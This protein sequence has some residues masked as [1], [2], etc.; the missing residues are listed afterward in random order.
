M[1]VRFVFEKITPNKLIFKKV[2]LAKVEDRAGG[3]RYEES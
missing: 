3:K 2:T 1:T